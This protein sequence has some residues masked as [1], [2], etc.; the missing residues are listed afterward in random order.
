[1]VTAL[2]W[3]YRE[4]AAP[5]LV[6]GVFIVGQMLGMGLLHRNPLLEGALVLLADVPSGAVV[7]SGLAIGAA[8]SWLGWQAGTRKAERSGGGLAAVV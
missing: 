2:W 6:A 3:R 7:G 5:F 4:K 8:T 1:V